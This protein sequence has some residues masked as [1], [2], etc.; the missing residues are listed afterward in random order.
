M[1]GRCLKSVCLP[2][3]LSVLLLLLL[4]LMIIIIFSFTCHSSVE[5]YRRKMLLLFLFCFYIPANEK[6][7]SCCK[8]KEFC[9]LEYLPVCS[10]FSLS[11]SPSLHFPHP[12]L[13]S[14]HTQYPLCLPFITVPIQVVFLYSRS[15]LKKSPRKRRKL[16][17]SIS[18]FILYRHAPVLLMLITQVS[19]MNSRRAC[20]VLHVSYI[21]IYLNCAFFCVLYTPL[22]PH[23]L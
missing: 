6:K 13:L 4:L 10:F 19:S 17:S 7:R 23:I 21:F 14:I 12:P 2:A 5:A 18:N 1:G 9:L 3:C 20:I 8:W 15:V 22:F 11:L 16:R